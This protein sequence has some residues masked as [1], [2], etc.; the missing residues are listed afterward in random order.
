MLDKV[1]DDLHDELQVRRG[2][3]GLERL[4]AGKSAKKDDEKTEPAVDKKAEKPGK[5]DA[6]LESLTKEE[7]ATLKARL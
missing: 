6:L 3:K 1:V 2:S 5:L 4:A 7:R